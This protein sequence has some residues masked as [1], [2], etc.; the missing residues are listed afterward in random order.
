MLNVCI[1]NGAT[2]YYPSVHDDTTWETK[3]RSSPG[4]FKF[5]V[6]LD[7]KLKITRGN[8]V[9]VKKGNE[10]VFKGY[11]FTC[12]ESEDHAKMSIT[13]Y[14]QLRYWKNKDT[15]T[16]NNMT[17]SEM[18]KKICRDFGFSMGDIT[19]TKFKITRIDQDKTI[20]DIIDNSLDETMVNTG[21]MYIYYDDYGKI[22]LKSLA[23]MKKKLLID[24]ETAQSY[25]YSSSIDSNTYNKVKLFYDNKDNG[26]REIYI[27]QDSS[28]MNMWGTLQYYESL[29]DPKQGKIKANALLKLYNTETKTLSIKEAFG[30]VSVRAGT[31]VVVQLVLNDKKI[32]NY[33][34]VETCKHK[35]SNGLHTMDLTL[36][37]GGFSAE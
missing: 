35:F 24:D 19:D 18:I 4:I 30:D 6:V 17:S 15:Y 12:Q 29:K 5:D 8:T 33:M 7:G 20:F 25:N 21:E 36:S 3:R 1:V 11:I 31:L 16:H 34:L 23:S 26:K 28:T 2:A 13:A 9:Y 22:T 37:G 10:E 27:A 14:D 32:C